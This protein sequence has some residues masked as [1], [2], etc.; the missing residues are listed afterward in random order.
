MNATPSLQSTYCPKLWNSTFITKNGD[1]FK[2]C[3]A[4][5]T[6]LGN[7]YEQRLRTIWNGGAYLAERA[8]SLAGRLDCYDSCTI[9]DKARVRMPPEIDEHCDYSS[10]AQL[11]IL[12][13]EGCNISCIMCWQPHGD[14][15]Q[16]DFSRLVDNVD[17]EHVTTIKM[18]GGEPLAIESLKQ[19]F[20]YAAARGKRLSLL[21]NGT[22][23]DAD[24]AHKV[25]RHSDF[26]T[27]SLNAATRSTHEAINRGSRWEQVLGNIR[28]LRA[29]RDETMSK[30]A[31]IGHMTIIPANIHEIG[32]FIERFESFGCDGA[33]FG[34]SMRVPAVLAEDA[35]LRERT[36]AGIASALEKCAQPE[37]VEVYRLGQ[38]G[39]V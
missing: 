9:L 30:L 8:K 23:L 11:H 28:Q 18:Q 21:T 31:I 37:R 29:I 1:V 12:F 36:V 4:T 15:S 38:L 6:L 25:V 34:Y 20:S 14:R 33:N 19:Y 39:L 16:L 35:E 24:W 10:L 3:H 17:I 27:V 7:I 22:L 5:N 2:C 32:L 26:L 13:G